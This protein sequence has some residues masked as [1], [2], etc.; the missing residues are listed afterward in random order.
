MILKRINILTF[1]NLED[2]T[3][4]FN[5]KINLIIGKNG[6]GKTNLLNAIY[7]LSSGN[8]FNNLKETELP[9]F[10]QASFYLC[11]SFFDSDFNNEI[12]IEIIYKEKRKIISINGKPIQSQKELIGVI[13]VIIFNFRTKDI[14]LKEPELR[15]NFLDTHISM[16][17]KD[18]KNAISEYS[19]ILQSKNSTL[20]KLKEERG[21]FYLEVLLDS[22]NEKLFEKGYII[23]EKREFF[24]KNL[25]NELK[26]LYKKNVEISYEPKIITI[27]GLNKIKDE[28]IERGYG[29]IGPHLDD[30][31][32][33]YKGIEV[34]TLFSLGEIEELSL[35]LI[36]SLYQILSFELNK[37]PIIL[38]DDLFETVDKEK[39][40][41]LTGLL[42]NFNQVILTSFSEEIVPVE[43]K[44]KSSTFFLKKKE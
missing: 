41:S 20:K 33:L 13:P 40:E 7:Y 37:K 25:S 36:L 27:Q 2:L 39:L 31:N 29:L 15:R 26:N 17:D 16:I 21:N 32:F 6:S 43:L 4:D 34:K 3:F 11:G 10:P 30:L 19:D 22:L 24:I 1:R 42:Y 14:I 12:K 44:K 35:Y 5:E 38:I 8:T 9:T 18:Y 28:E 23:Q